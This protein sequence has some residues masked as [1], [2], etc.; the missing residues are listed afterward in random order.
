MENTDGG[1]GFFYLRWAL[2][3]CRQWKTIM[4]QY[5]TSFSDAVGGDEIPVEQL[6]VGGVQ[7]IKAHALM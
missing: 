5:R 7:V 3:A 6:G 1:Q 4:P 2:L